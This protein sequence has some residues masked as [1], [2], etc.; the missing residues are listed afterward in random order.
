MLLSFFYFQVG[1]ALTLVQHVLL[2]YATITQVCSHLKMIALAQFVT[3]PPNI[4]VADRAVSASTTTIKNR[5]SLMCVCVRERERHKREAGFCICSSSAFDSRWKSWQKLPWQQ[6]HNSPTGPPSTSVST[7]CSEA[8]VLNTHSYRWLMAGWSYTS[9]EQSVE[10]IRAP[11]AVAEAHCCSHLNE[12]QTAGII[13]GGV[14]PLLLRF[15]YAVNPETV[16]AK[17][18]SILFCT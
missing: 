9:T 16:D 1:E 4:L 13:L 2:H 7:L 8:E 11:P 6:S 15:N 5:Y 18:Q 12:L 3:I 14:K 10:Q 17:S